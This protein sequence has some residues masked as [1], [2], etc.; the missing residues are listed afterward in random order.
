MN[1]K[2][3]VKR[4]LINALEKLNLTVESFDLSSSKNPK[5]GDLSTNV[6]LILAKQV[7]KNPMEIATE[8]KQAIQFDNSILSYINVTQP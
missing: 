3:I 8:I 6:A 1:L 5:F 4:Y 7:G 2:S